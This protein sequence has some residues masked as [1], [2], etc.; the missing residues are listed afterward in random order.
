MQPTFTDI[1]THLANNHEIAVI[2]ALEDVLEIRPDLSEEQAWEVLQAAM[3]HH[4]AGI[5]INWNVLEC[6]ADMLFGSAPDNDA[7]EEN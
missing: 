2:W 5:G 4:D 6:H 3:H 1:H 7:P